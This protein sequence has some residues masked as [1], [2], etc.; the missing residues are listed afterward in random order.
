MFI[1][2]AMLVTHTTMSGGV[3]VVV[4]YILEAKVAPMFYCTYFS[5]ILCL[6]VKSVQLIHNDRCQ[7]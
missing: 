5:S 1:A 2:I 6:R 4:G 3:V 7:P